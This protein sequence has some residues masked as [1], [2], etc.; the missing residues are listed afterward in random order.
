MT[1]RVADLMDEADER[2]E[3]AEAERL[4]HIAAVNDRTFEDAIGTAIIRPA[5]PKPRKAWDALA[6][7]TG[8]ALMLGAFVAYTAWAQGALP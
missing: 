2:A 4:A 6:Y 1:I 3:K 5:A 7:W 8:V